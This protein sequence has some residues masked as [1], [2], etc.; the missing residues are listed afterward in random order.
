[1]NSHQGSVYFNQG[2][3]FSGRDTLRKLVIVDRTKHTLDR[4][5]LD[6]E[7]K[8]FEILKQSGK[9]ENPKP[10]KFK[11]TSVIVY[12]NG[13]LF[14]GEL[15]SI[16]DKISYDKEWKQ[17]LFAKMKSMK[18][19]L[20]DALHIEMEKGWY[21][22][23]K[24]FEYNDAKWEQFICAVYENVKVLS[25]SNAKVLPLLNDFK[26]S[27]YKCIKNNASASSNQYG[28]RRKTKRSKRSMRLTRNKKCKRRT[29]RS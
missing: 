14:T 4:D 26:N 17:L 6:L 10:P 18:L 1:M 23:K 12:P 13:I 29:R 22:F 16:F 21:N 3:H 28:G 24:P 2:R 8:K 9:E 15:T 7:G 25:L 19:P 11:D 27:H 5:T 20:G